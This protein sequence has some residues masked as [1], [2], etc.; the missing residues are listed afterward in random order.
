MKALGFP[1]WGWDPGVALFAE[2]SSRLVA[3]GE[4]GSTHASLFVAGGTGV[5]ERG[6]CY[7]HVWA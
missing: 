4:M 2:L 7:R 3:A 6:E 1:K 5:G